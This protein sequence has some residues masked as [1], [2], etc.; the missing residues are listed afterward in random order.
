MD[1]SNE[2][3]TKVHPLDDIFVNGFDSWQETHY[4]IVSMM[5]LGYERGDPVI[6]EYMSVKGIGGMYELA[7]ELT[8]KFE[9][10]HK[11]R[12]WDGDFF[13]ELEYFM[14]R[15]IKKIS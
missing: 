8:T 5:T 11:G 6:D 15:E 3:A 2:L 10:E 12:V 14:Y 4:E 7:E 13:E 9:M 1:K